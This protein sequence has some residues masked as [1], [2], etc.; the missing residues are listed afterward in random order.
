MHLTQKELLVLRKNNRY[1]WKNQCSPP[2]L[3]SL[4]EELINYS[5]HAVYMFLRDKK[6]SMFAL[7]MN[8]A[9]LEEHNELFVVLANKFDEGIKNAYNR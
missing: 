8:D 1:W 2:L 3:V 6:E 5:S 9:L 7:L 4:L